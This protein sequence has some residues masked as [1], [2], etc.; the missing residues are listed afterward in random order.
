MKKEYPLIKPLV[1][2]NEEHKE[3]VRKLFEKRFSF[4]Q[5]EKEYPQYLEGTWQAEIAGL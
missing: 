3:I 5:N 1:E 2:L 4:N